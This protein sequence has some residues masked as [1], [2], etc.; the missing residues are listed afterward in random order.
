M[1]F[2]LPATA[3][4]ISLLTPSAAEMVYSVKEAHIS[5]DTGFNDDYSSEESTFIV[6]SVVA[7]YNEV[8]NPRLPC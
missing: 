6:N 7:A 4:L 5:F 2:F 8:H 3:S 1:R